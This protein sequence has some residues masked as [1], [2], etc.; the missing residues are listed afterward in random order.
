MRVGADETL[1]LLD[2]NTFPLNLGLHVVQ[3]HCHLIQHSRLHAAPL[4][5]RGKDENIQLL[6]GEVGVRACD[7]QAGCL[8]LIRPLA[9]CPSISLA[10]SIPVPRVPKG[11][12]I[13]AAVQVL[14]GLR[15]D[16]GVTGSFL[17]TSG[18]LETGNGHAQK[19]CVQECPGSHVM[20]SHVTHGPVCIMKSKKVLVSPPLTS[21]ILSLL[22]SPPSLSL[23][24]SSPPLPCPLNCLFS[25]LFCFLS[26]LLKNY[27]SF[28]VFL[29]VPE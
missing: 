24:L 10:P 1:S 22:P 2:P 13:K 29:C 8:D 7:N 4:P 26:L 16:P 3:I 17:S 23:P 11:K 18:L 12:K 19:V 28:C 20:V 9:G 21:S 6:A 15:R 25:P 14:A 5:L 27:L